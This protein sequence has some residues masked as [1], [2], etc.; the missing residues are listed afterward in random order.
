MRGSGTVLGVLYYHV[1]TGQRPAPVWLW[2]GL[3]LGKRWERWD[4]LRAGDTQ[5]LATPDTSTLSLSLSL[6][7]SYSRIFPGV[8][9]GGEWESCSDQFCSQFLNTVESLYKGLWQVSILVLVT[10]SM[11]QWSALYG[12][13]EQIWCVSQN[14]IFM[15]Q[16]FPEK[17]EV[18]SASILCLWSEQM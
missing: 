18:P 14:T 3:R 13:A 12:D 6:S 1:F 10:L 9:A 2:S 16:I 4:S 17:L 5:T 11:S 7:R 8:G 15:L